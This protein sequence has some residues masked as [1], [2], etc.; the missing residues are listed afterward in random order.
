MVDTNHSTVV[1]LETLSE[2][3]DGIPVGLHASSYY[4]VIVVDGAAII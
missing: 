3:G 4:E 2:T 1:L